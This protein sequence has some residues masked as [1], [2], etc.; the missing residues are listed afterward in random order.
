MVEKLK[1]ISDQP[2][3]FATVV[4]VERASILSA[5]KF[6]RG[7]TQEALI[8]V[9]SSWHDLNVEEIFGESVIGCFAEDALRTRV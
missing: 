4:P 3:G 8:L 6:Y 2:Q 9:G 7:K 1:I 5:D